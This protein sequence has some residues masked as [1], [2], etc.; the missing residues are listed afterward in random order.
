MDPKNTKLN[1]SQARH[2]QRIIAEPGTVHA[3]TCIGGGFN[4]LTFKAL[5]RRGLIHADEK[6]GWRFIPTA[7]GLTVAGAA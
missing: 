7:A 2:L 5:D 6:T 4:A 1:E 3:G